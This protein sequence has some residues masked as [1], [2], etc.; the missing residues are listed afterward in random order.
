MFHKIDPHDSIR[1]RGLHLVTCLLDATPSPPPVTQ[2]SLLLSC[3]CGLPLVFRYCFSQFPDVSQNWFSKRLQ[4]PSAF[5]QPPCRCCL[6]PVTSCVCLADAVFS[7]ASELSYA[8]RPQLS[9]VFQARPAVISRSRFIC[10]L[11]AFEIWSSKCLY[12]VSLAF[13]CFPVC[14]VLLGSPAVSLY[15]SPFMCLVVCPYKCPALH[16]PSL[17]RQKAVGFQLPDA[18]GGHHRFSFPPHMYAG[19]REAW[20]SVPHWV[21]QCTR[22]FVFHL[23]SFCRPPCSPLRL[24]LCHRHCAPLCFAACFQLCLQLCTPLRFPMCLAVRFASSLSL[25]FVSI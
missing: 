19:F 20:S 10:F 17:Q 6:P 18:G 24:P 25:K 4:M 2:L 8:C 1:V 21:S 9:T 16:L 11:A 15:L 5:A 23:N 7:I 12:I 3:R 13:I 14:L 22:H